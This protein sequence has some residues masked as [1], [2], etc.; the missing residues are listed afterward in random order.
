MCIRPVHP[1]VRGD[2]TTSPLNITAC[3]GS[4][5]RAWGRWH[6][7]PGLRFR[8]RFTPTCVGTMPCVQLGT[9]YMTVHPHVRGDDQSP[10]LGSWRNAGSPPRAWGRF[11]IDRG[12]ELPVRFTPTCVGTMRAA[13]SERSRSTVHPHVRGDGASRMSSPC[14]AD[15][16]PPRAWGR[17]PQDRLRQILLRFTPT[18]VGTM[19]GKRS[20]GAG[21]PVHPHVRGDD[22]TVKSSTTTGVGSPPRAW[23]RSMITPV[24]SGAVRFTPTC[25][26]TM[27]HDVF[28]LVNR[29]RKVIH[30]GCGHFSGLFHA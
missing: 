5:P 4:P 26:G 7:R 11:F 24:V 9:T 13:R 27:L 8:S 22:P 17:Y 2:D 18:C 6:G 3:P 15:G 28:L 1:H 12:E 21:I 30:W 19:T 10:V 25:V 16:S 20:R 14:R 29:G 23:G